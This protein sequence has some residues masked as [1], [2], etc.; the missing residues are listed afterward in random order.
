MANIYIHKTTIDDEVILKILRYI[1]R[2]FIRREEGDNCYF[3][4]IKSITNF[5]KSYLNNNVIKQLTL[6]LL[7]VNSRIAN[8]LLIV[9][10]R[11]PAML[12][13]YTKKKL[14]NLRE[15]PFY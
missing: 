12:L 4:F 9:S 1:N 13:A 11:R 10:T 2:E 6:K 3:Y 7:A 8:Q 14:E 5:E 15:E